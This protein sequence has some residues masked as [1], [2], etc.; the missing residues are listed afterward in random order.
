[1]LHH[2]RADLPE[3]KPQYTKHCICIKL[4]ARSLAKSC[5][6]TK[7]QGMG[8][9]MTFAYWSTRNCGPSPEGTSFPS[10]S[11]PYVLIN[12]IEH[13]LLYETGLARGQTPIHKTLH[14]P[15]TYRNCGP[16]PEGTSFPSTSSPYVLINKIEHALLYETGLA[17]GQTPIHKTL[18]LPQ[19]Y[20]Q[21]SCAD[22]RGLQNQTH[23]ASGPFQRKFA[24][25][26][27]CVTEGAN[28]GLVCCLP[29]FFSFSVWNLNLN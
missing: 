2:M 9:G 26:L 24:K 12:R 23:L 18:H 14:L 7:L 10:T 16:S 27:A 11:S 8:K 22:T 15:Q 3:D 28:S 5:H 25:S 17:R 21:Q 1:M 4:T 20:R 19:T 6:L 13:A 29:D